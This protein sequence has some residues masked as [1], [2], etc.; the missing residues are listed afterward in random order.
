MRKHKE[1]SFGSMS[2]VSMSSEILLVYS[3]GFW[4]FICAS[5]IYLMPFV[6]LLDHH[7]N[8]RTKLIMTWP[9]KTA[10]NSAFSCDGAVESLRYL[11]TEIRYFVTENLIMI[12][13]RENQVSRYYC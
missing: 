7:R 12:F 9:I 13:V 11:V 8:L 5:P 4:I 1:S 2:M 6:W 10:V 3:V